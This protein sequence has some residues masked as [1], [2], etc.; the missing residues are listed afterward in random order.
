MINRA[1]RSHRMFLATIHNPRIG[2]HAIIVRN[3]S[4]HGIG[5][6]VNQVHLS[7]GEAVSVRFEAVG[8]IEGIVRWAKGTT[9]GVELATDLDLAMFSF[10]GKSWDVAN[11][12]FDGTDV[13][14]QIK[15]A[16]RSR[17]P[18]LKTH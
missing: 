15:P 13:Y 16:G 14:R 8:D 3:I 6:R 4:A 17:R 18:G 5:A 12:Q 10:E 9:I 2:E 7:E 1:L 11:K